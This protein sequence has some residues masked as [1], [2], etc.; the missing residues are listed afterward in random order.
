MAERVGLVVLGRLWIT[1]LA[2][3]KA[4]R[5]SEAAVQK[6]LLLAQH[7][8]HLAHHAMGVLEFVGHLLAH[9]A[10]AQV[11]QY[12]L[13]LAQHFESRVPGPV[14]RQ[15]PGLVD[16]LL[17]ILTFDQAPVRVHVG[18]HLA[19]LHLA[20]GLLGQGFEETIQSLLQLVHEALDLFVVGTLRQGFH[21]GFLD[22]AQV[23]F[24]EAQLALLDPQ[25]GL[26]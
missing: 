1:P 24:G 9:R 22:A 12:V 7:V 18:R 25:R 20:Q 8:L 15:A 3:A 23:A 26:P 17:Q 6:I 19:A 16:Q 5:A 14:L 13:Q 4:F 21:E 11:L 2:G 10:G